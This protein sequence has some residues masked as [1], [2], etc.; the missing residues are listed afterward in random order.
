MHD[1]APA[2]TGEG[3]LRSRLDA[4]PSATALKLIKIAAESGRERGRGPARCRWGG[5]ALHS[6][7][8]AVRKPM[9]GFAVKTRFIV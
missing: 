8:C 4:A 3:Q 2:P 7:R 9:R 1:D 6:G 5:Y